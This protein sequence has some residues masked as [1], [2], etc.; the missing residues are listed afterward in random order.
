MLHEFDQPNTLK[1]I[2]YY[3]CLPVKLENVSN[4][5]VDIEIYMKN[6]K[7]FTDA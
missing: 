6:I 3:F 4:F 5:Y 2:Q 7:L 1:K